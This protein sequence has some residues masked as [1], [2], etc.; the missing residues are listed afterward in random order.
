MQAQA[1]VDDK[2]ALSIAQSKG[3][4]DGTI[5]GKNQQLRDASAR[6]LLSELFDN[7]EISQI[8]YDTARL[9]FD[10]AN[11]EVDKFRLIIRYVETHK[12]K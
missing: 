11:Y 4:A 9:N 6:E 12:E 10:L 8:A 3:L 2:T 5:T 1:L 7:V